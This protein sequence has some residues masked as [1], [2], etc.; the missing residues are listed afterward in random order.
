MKRS[1][2]GES[3]GAILLT[4]DQLLLPLSC[5]ETVICVR[6]D[7]D[8]GLDASR[9]QRDKNNKKKER[10][11]IQEQVSNYKCV[12]E[13]KVTTKA[14]VNGESYHLSL[15]FPVNGIRSATD[16]D[17]DC[18]NINGYLRSCRAIK[19][20]TCIQDVKKG[21]NSKG[22]TKRWSG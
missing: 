22:R 17:L 9:E 2:R 12:K 15:V 1:T 5:A 18:K 20:G 10:M 14:G 8:R 7:Q 11:Q 13:R 4:S 19:T 6:E 16:R 3:H 21:K